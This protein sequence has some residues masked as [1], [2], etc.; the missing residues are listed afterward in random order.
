MEEFINGTRPYSEEERRRDKQADDE[1][2]KRHVAR[3]K[4]R[5][6]GQRYDTPAT[7]AHRRL[8]DRMVGSQ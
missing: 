3:R 5:R 1:A 2:L 7:P 6:S 8:Y 4:A